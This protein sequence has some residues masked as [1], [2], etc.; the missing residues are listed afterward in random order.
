MLFALPAAWLVG[1]LA[2][3]GL[4]IAN[5]L[6]SITTFSF[7][8]IG[9]LVALNVKLPNTWL[10]GVGGAF[11]LLHGFVNGASTDWLCYA[12]ATITILTLVTLLAAL[13]VSLRAYWARI[14]V[15]AAGSWM[16]A[17]GLLMLGWLARGKG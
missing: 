9:A 11:G 4:P 1:A 10:T 7:G 16:A 15:R 14:I 12:G 8:F 5:S 3:S 6:Q 13:A 2:G 17:I